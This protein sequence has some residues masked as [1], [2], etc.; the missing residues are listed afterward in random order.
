MMEM[1]NHIL[2]SVAL[3]G[4]LIAIAGTSCSLA[5]SVVQG[6]AKGIWRV[7][8]QNNTTYYSVLGE[9]NSS[10]DQTTQLSVAP[11]NPAFIEYR[12]R[13]AEQSKNAQKLLTDTENADPRLGYI[14][15][16]CIYPTTG[17]LRAHIAW[18]AQQSYQL[19]LPLTTCER[20]ER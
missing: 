3:V 1:S 13:V 19:I 2:L 17:L 11:L 8:A 12:Q 6:D 15:P 18:T 5:D 14:P 9:Q 16:P 10:T 20:L 7:D 4:L